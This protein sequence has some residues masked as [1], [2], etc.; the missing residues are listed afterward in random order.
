VVAAAL[1][2]KAMLGVLVVVVVRHI[3]QAVVVVQVALV[4]MQLVTLLV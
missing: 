3:H 4:E 2:V 1:L